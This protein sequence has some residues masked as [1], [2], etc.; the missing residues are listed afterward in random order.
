MYLH[1]Q[2]VATSYSNLLAPPLETDIHA[3]MEGEM[4]Y[5]VAQTVSKT[6]TDDRCAYSGNTDVLMYTQYLHTHAAPEA[7]RKFLKRTIP[8]ALERMLPVKLLQPVTHTLT[9]TMSRALT[10]ILTPTLTVMLSR[11]PSE[12]VACSYCRSVHTVAVLLSTTATCENGTHSL[13]PYL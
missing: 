13:N 6:G 5:R 3:A 11:N 7:I 10:H 2:A 8:L 4:A 12:H 1:P 9:Q